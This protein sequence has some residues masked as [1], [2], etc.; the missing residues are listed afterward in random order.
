ML[1]KGANHYLPKTTD[2]DGR[3]RGSRSTEGRSGEQHVKGGAHR[4]RVFCWTPQ[5]RSSMGDGWWRKG[6]GVAGESAPQA[7]HAV[8]DNMDI[9]CIIISTCFYCD[10][11]IGLEMYSD[12]H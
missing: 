3:T 5:T 4:R 2:E 10:F 8:L 1:S 7:A 9:F 6:A 12:V 11:V